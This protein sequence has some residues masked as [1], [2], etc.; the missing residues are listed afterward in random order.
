MAE[1]VSTFHQDTHAVHSHD[2]YHQEAE[3][4]HLGE[5]VVSKRGKG[6]QVELGVSQLKLD[7]QMIKTQLRHF[8]VTELL[9]QH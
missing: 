6:K 3:G 7:L 2:A 5:D 4:T 9:A 8:L 1:V